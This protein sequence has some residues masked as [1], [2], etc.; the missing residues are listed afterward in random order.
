MERHRGLADALKAEPGIEITASVD[1]AW[2]Q[3]VAGEKM[4]SILQDNKDINLVF[5]QNDRMAVG[6]YLSARQRQLEKEMLFSVSSGYLDVSVHRV[7]LQRYVLALGY[8]RFAQVGFPIQ[9]SPDHWIFAPPRS[10]SQLITSF[11]GSQCQ[12]IRPAPFFA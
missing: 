12:G 6:A 5:A 11:I 7:P 2:L 4:D 1:G 8:L 9:I 3:S 10:L